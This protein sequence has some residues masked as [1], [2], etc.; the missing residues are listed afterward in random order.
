MKST[1]L[2]NGV[3][4]LSES[5]PGVRSVALG[6]WV[7]HGAAHDPASML[8]ASHL[9]EHMVFKGTRH[10]SARELVLA[11]EGIGGSLDAYTSREHTGYQA[12]VLDEFTELGIDVVSDLVRSP[13]L[14]QSDLDLER[15]VVLEEIS[16]VDETPDDLVFEL[17]GDFLWRGH[18]YGRPIL[19][20]RD[21]V[22]GIDAIELSRLHDS[23]Y[24][25]QNLV[26]AAAGSVEHD[27]WVEWVERRLGG[28][29]TRTVPSRLDPARPRL[30]A[31]TH[32][33]HD[34]V[35]SHIV[36]GTTIPGHSDPRRHA[37][38]ILSAAF[39]GGMSS[40]LFQR[41]R[42][43]L[44]LGY[45]VYSYQSFHRGAGVSGMYLGTRPGWER[46]ALQAIREEYAKVAREGLPDEEL[47]RTKHQVR[48]QFL[49]SLEST[50]A[51]LYR[52]AGHA[53][54]DEPYR[55]VD[56]VLARID[57]VSAD[58]VRA[59]AA[60]FYAPERQ[61]ALVLGPESDSDGRVL[62]VLGDAWP[63]LATNAGH[64]GH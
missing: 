7:R 3:L 58:D 32:V 40:R 15:H 54:Y 53:L 2:D 18:P 26:A 28:L 59:A 24:C 51:R 21:T 38:M 29:P 1:L 42:E 25:G 16:Q 4:V 46:K 63:E 5:V 17:H 37:L 55:E 13:S 14:R 19:G 61:T 20:T 49:I 11:L 30:G 45:A 47:E 52:L 48:G 57:G 41:L 31:G 56:E 50:S 64:T 9:L 34:G 12:R 43:D 10:R 60:E 23:F 33:P 44:A 62:D 39:G 22:S 36:L 6:V 27:R 35:Q 8:G